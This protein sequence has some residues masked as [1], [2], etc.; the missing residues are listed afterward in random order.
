MPNC[1]AFVQDF[2]IGGFEE[3]DYGTGAVAGSLDCGDASVSLGDCGRVEGKS[4]WG[5]LYRF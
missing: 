4:G 3:L 1:C 5:R 2:D